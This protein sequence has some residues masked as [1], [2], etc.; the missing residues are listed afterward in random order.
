MKAISMMQ[1]YA[2]LFSIGFLVID[3][4][5]WTTSY[6]GPLLIHASKKRDE[7]YEAFLKKQGVPVPE[8]L[9]HGGF[10]GMG[11]LTAVLNPGETLSSIENIRRSHF[12]GIKNKKGEVCFF[13]GLV[14]DSVE[15]CGFIPY[16]G[17]PGLFDVDATRFVI[18][19]KIT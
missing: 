11:K 12:G 2:W 13:Y 5:S 14:I 4:R 9:A 1:P 18:D 19:S 10:I 17:L 6:R 8:I 16:K 3:D 15:E 7:K